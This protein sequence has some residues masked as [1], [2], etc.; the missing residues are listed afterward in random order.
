MP[1]T[2]VGYGVSGRK[3]RCPLTPSSYKWGC[4]GREGVSFP[5]LPSSLPPLRHRRRT[6][7]LLNTAAA[8]ALLPGFSCSSFGGSP[9]NTA[10]APLRRRSAVLRYNI[11]LSR[12]NFRLVVHMCSCSSMFSFDF[13]TSFDLFCPLILVVT[14]LSCIESHYFLAYIPNLTCPFS[15]DRLSPFSSIC[16]HGGEILIPEFSSPD[17]KLK[18]CCCSHQARRG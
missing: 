4:A 11:S 12:F 8:Q 7:L 9:A 13:F 18:L 5:H 10:A 2:C 17:G 3:V 14:S 1:I 16:R 15:L 6:A